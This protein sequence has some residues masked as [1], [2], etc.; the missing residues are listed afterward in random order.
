MGRMAMRRFV[1]TSA[2]A[3]VAGGFVAAASAQQAAQPTP[4]ATPAAAARTAASAARRLQPDL[5]VI[6]DDQVRIEELRV[7]GQ[8]QRITVAPK[9]PPGSKLGPYEINVGA[10]GR[11]PSQDKGAAGQRVWSLWRF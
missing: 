6:E 11:D 1:R 7:H 5:R 9:G 10:G 2:T 4:A 3:L 8:L